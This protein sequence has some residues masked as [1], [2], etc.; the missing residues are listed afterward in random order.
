MIC[1]SFTEIGSRDYQGVAQ[2]LYFLGLK[3][4]VVETFPWTSVLVSLPPPAGQNTISQK[5]QAKVISLSHEVMT[6]ISYRV[7]FPLDFNSP[8]KR[9]SLTIQ[10]LGR[11]GA[12]GV[13]KH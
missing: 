9:C 4:G 2:H 11:S 1:R 8:L 6:E 12:N 13:L 7:Q 10:A 3:C 5:G